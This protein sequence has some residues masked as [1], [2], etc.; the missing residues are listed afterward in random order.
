[1]FL[2]E[3]ESRPP[4]GMMGIAFKKMRENGHTVPDIMHLFRFKKSATDHLVRFTDEVM[5]GPS[6]LSPGLRELIG[7]F[8]SKRNQCGFCSCAHAP[9]A[10]ELLGN[11]LVEEV[12]QD[13]ES[14]RLDRAH[15][16]LFRYLAKL[17]DSSAQTTAA[18]VDKLK[19]LGWSEEAIY[20]A[21][22]VA[23]LFKFYNTWNNGSGVRDMRTA[24][25]RHSSERL[26]TMGYCM[27]FGV[28]GILKVMWV[29][30]KEVN[31]GDLKWL[32]KLALTK[33]VN[34]FWPV[35]LKQQRFDKP[36]PRPPVSCNLPTGAT[37]ADRRSAHL[38]RD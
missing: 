3:I 29:G 20:D 25:Y 8:V 5:R 15:K 28:R 23:A 6:P 19:E 32:A 30:R 26:L 37:S 35:A 24:D 34:V 21:L 7:A 18:D 31:Y 2:K 9:V 13:V 1:M 36:E 14:S 12:L 38:Q 17:T 27:D 22:T 11:E 16:E 33:F 4:E 10:A